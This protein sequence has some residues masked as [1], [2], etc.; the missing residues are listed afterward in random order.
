MSVGR[1]SPWLEAAGV[2]IV[3]PV[4]NP[5]LQSLRECA[6]SLLPQLRTNVEWILVDDG[7]SISDHFDF[8]SR[9]E[10]HQSITVIRNGQNAGIS[11][12][13]NDGI[14]V[15]NGSHI[16]FLDQDDLLTPDACRLVCQL[17]EADNEI[18]VLYSDEDK[19]DA[20]GN[21][22]GRFRKPEWS[23][24]R[25]RHQN[26]LS[27][28]TVIRR[29]LIERV[30]G[31]R[32]EFDGSQDFDLALRCTEK[33]EKI[34][35]IPKVLYH[36]RSIPSST[37]S[38]PNAK[39]AAHLASVRAVQEHL[40]RLGRD[41]S[42]SLMPNMY[43]DVQRSPVSHP[44]VSV[45]IP[46][47]GSEARIGGALTCLVENCV[48]S[49]L[50]LSTY[51]ALE[52]IVVLDDDSPSGLAD[53]LRSMDSERVTVL[54]YADDFNFST[55]INLGALAS[56]GDIL[57]PLNDDIQVVSPSWIEE[58]LVYLEEPDVGMVAPL[59]LLEDGRVQSAGHFFDEGVH[60]VGAGLAFGDP[61]PFGVLSFPAER[62]GATFA[63]VAVRRDVFESV[64][65]LCEDLPRAFNDVDFGNKIRRSGFR[66]IFTPRA[67]LHHFESLTRDSRVEEFE[68]NNLY[69]RWGSLVTDYDEY[70]PLFWRQQYAIDR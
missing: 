68:V 56:Q 26:Y 51:S 44:V 30:G 61:G 10:R 52:I 65:G 36:W 60:H 40:N 3:T 45:I 19:I 20:E 57:V 62:S 24:E 6:E 1:I 8:L 41:G 25:L 17:L 48:A 7:S 14:A 22:F 50:T 46:S 27:H 66:I 64:G 33:A 37:A 2:S 49:V 38:D 16:A 11:S 42:A 59:L 70:L 47:C 54:S 55:K 67:V 58:L 21:F 5:P 23:P 12:A 28:L 35:H 63:A 18:D 9:L 31:L 43:V 32:S 53:R 34:I 39:P 13:T 15:A 69:R 4:F 29:A